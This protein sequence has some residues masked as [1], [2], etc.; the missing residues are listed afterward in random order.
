MVT[1]NQTHDSQPEG[2][3]VFYHAFLLI[4]KGVFF[5]GRKRTIHQKHE[6]AAGYDG[7]LGACQ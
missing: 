1:R 4:A 3:D 6:N 2:M 7:R 5:Y